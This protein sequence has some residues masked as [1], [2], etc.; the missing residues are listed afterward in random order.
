MTFA[1]NHPLRRWS[2]RCLYL[3]FL[4]ILFAAVLHDSAW[5]IIFGI[6]ALLSFLL[7]LLGIILGAR[8]RLAE[9]RDERLALARICPS[10]G[11]DLRATPDRCPECGAVP[12]GVRGT[13]K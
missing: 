5:T 6:C 1:A 12:E 2:R 3:S 11:Y 7:M 4:A 13:S 10:C 8:K 9:N